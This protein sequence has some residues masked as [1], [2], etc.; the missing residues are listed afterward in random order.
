MYTCQFCERDMLMN[1]VTIDDKPA[2][3]HCAYDDARA[4][5]KAKRRGQDV[6]PG[7]RAF[8]IMLD[9]VT[10]FDETGRFQLGLVEDEEESV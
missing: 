10:K 4:K 5:R 1:L 2:H 8:P 7:G 3:L 9:K 6:D